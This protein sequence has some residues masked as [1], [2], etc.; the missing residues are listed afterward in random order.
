MRTLAYFTFLYLLFLGSAAG[1]S[2]ERGWAIGLQHRSIL[3]EGEIDEALYN[4]VDLFHLQV[5]YRWNARWETGLD[6]NHLELWQDSP[7]L[8]ID[9]YQ[10]VYLGR[11]ERDLRLLLEG[12]AGTDD[13]LDAALPYRAYAVGLG[14]GAYLRLTPRFSATLGARYV[15]LLRNY[16]I[17]RTEIGNSGA[18]LFTRPLESSQ[19][20]QVEVRLAVRYHF[21]GR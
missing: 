3:T 15:R 9:L 21:G 2:A 11:L 6:F 20:G 1:Q 12:V 4:T 13:H 19:R 7:V 18:F 10:R 14:G 8:D 17:E 16:R 5:A